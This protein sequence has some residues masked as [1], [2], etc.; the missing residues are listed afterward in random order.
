MNESACILGNTIKSSRLYMGGS[1]GILFDGEEA[2]PNQSLRIHPQ[3]GNNN[4][5]HQKKK[6][7]GFKTNEIRAR[8]IDYTS[9][10]SYPKIY[11]PVP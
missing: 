2:T 1:S 6:E 8:Y 11:Y 10:E 5:G 7:R 4:E 3:G 9:E